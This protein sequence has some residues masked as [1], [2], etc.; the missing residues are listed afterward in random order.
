MTTMTRAPETS[1]VLLAEAPRA[2]APAPE[3]RERGHAWWAHL[4]WVV[5]ASIMGF[6]IPALF[7]GGLHVTREF[8]VLPYFCASAVFLYLYVRWSGV[9]VYARLRQHWVWGVV[10]AIVAGV[11][12]VSNVLNQPASAAPSGLELVGAILWL[13]VVYG[14]T[15]ALLLSV[16]PLFATWQALSRLGWTHRWYGR[17][18]SGVLALAAS[19]VVAGVYHLGFPEFRGSSVVAPIIGNGVMSLASLVTMNPI[20]AVGAHVAM[21]IGAVLHGAET[22]LQLPPH[23]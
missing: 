16:L 3:I 2:V 20:A 8:F 21:H 14:T 15:D 22:T 6:A 11:F 10:G 9:D 5:G 19:L 1:S 13:G 12:V 18:G 23:Y 4:A 7:A 17:V